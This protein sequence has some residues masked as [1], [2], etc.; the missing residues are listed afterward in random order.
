MI[1][2]QNETTVTIA[3]PIEPRY[4]GMFTTEGNHAVS[5]I[6][7]FAKAN[8]AEWENVLPML[9]N[10]ALSNPMYREANDTVVREMVYDACSF[11]SDFY[12]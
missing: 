2:S 1:V 5:L 8:G 3:M 7:E 6:V 9:N 11:T 10:L 4:F 12:V